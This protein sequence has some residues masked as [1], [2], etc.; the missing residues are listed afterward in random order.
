MPA[1]ENSV[2]NSGRKASLTRPNPASSRST[3][4]TEPANAPSSSATVHWMPVPVHGSAPS[5]YSTTPPATRAGVPSAP[6][7]PPFAMLY[8][9]SRA[10]E[11]H[12]RHIV[13]HEE[14]LVL[15]DY[16][17]RQSGRHVH[18]GLVILRVVAPLE[19]CAH[20]LG[21]KL[22][23]PLLSTGTVFVE[24]LKQRAKSPLLQVAF[25]PRIRTYQRPLAL[26]LRTA[27]SFP[28]FR[29]SLKFVER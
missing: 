6:C 19:T 14:L 18:D 29:S 7:S 12:G 16:S 9:S 8:P 17:L 23:D 2:P 13:V 15:L 25:L 5:S 26:V 3:A 11:T 28:N 4:A 24:L 10:A 22:P 1:V 21:T 20:G 27:A